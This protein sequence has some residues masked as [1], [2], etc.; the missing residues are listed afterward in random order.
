M[1]NS[2]PL[3]SV[4]TVNYYCVDEIKGWIKA[5]DELRGHFSLQKIVISNSEWGEDGIKLMKQYPD[6]VWYKAEQN[7]G[8][9]GGN[10]I[11]L[12]FA[13][14]DYIFFLNPDA[15]VKSNCIERLIRHCEDEPETGMVGP[16]TLDQHGRLLPSVKN[17]FSLLQLVQVCLPGLDRIF[18][19]NRKIGKYKLQKTDKVEVVNGSAMFLPASVIK[20]IG[21]MDERFFMY[22]EEHDLCFRL[23]QKG[24]QV[25]FNREA[26]VIHEGS[27]TTSPRFLE[28][29]IEKHKSQLIFLEKYFSS[30]ILINR[31]A[32]LMG[33]ALR[34][35]GAFLVMNK[36]KQK[37]FAAIFVWY[38]RSYSTF[39]HRKNSR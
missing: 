3:V 14:G 9:S 31:I 21:K 29:E 39:T 19:D 28:M 26:E 18:P 1:P 5:L 34:Y 15:R 25:W 8:F 4:I 13:K 23:M 24:K 6:I 36:Q 17:H 7:L 10:N 32:G 35:L 37:Q 22:W 11:G 33:Y 12:D 27:V 38:L 30:L 20:Q 16:A 2:K